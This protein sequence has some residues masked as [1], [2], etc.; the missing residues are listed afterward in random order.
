MN[1]REREVD[2]IVAG[3][4]HNGLVAAAYLAKAG[5]DVLVVEASPT[6]GGMTSTNPMAPEARA[7]LK[8]LRKAARHRK[9]IAEVVRWASS[10]QAETVEEHFESDIIRAALMIGL[11]FMSFHSDGSGWAL[12]YLGVLSKYGVAMFEGGT[13]S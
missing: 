7:R 8:S 13:G 6:I 3:A 11:P 5:F 2:V 12:I 4:G 9:K 1:A 10:S